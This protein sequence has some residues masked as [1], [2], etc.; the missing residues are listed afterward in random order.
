LP[1]FSLLPYDQEKGLQILDISQILDDKLFYNTYFHNHRVLQ[2]GNLTR[3]VHFQTTTPWGS[4]KKPTGTYFAWLHENEPFLNLIKFRIDTLIPCGFLVGA[5]PQFLRRDEAEEELSGS[6][7]MD[8]NP[9]PFQLASQNI[10]VL[11]SD[12]CKEHFTFQAIVIETS[13]KHAAN[14]QERFYEL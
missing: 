5:R 9:I 4:I 1:N 11:V 12:G 13:T 6:L 10:S 7:A 14:L 2:H 3:M 8:D